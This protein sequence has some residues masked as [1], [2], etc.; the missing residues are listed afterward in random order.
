MGG[1]DDGL[2]AR[3]FAMWVRFAL[4]LLHVLSGGLLG[5]PGGTGGERVIVR[6]CRP[7]EVIDVR[8]AVL[9]PGRP[10]DTAIFAGDDAPTTRHWLATLAGRGVGV[11]TVLDSREPDEADPAVLQL[12]GMAVL[13]EVQG[14]GVGRALLD[15]VWAELAP[16][17]LWCNAREKAIPFYTRCGWVE[18]GD[19]FEIA[20]I[21]PH[22]R[23]RWIGGP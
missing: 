5:E 19:R 8:H 21:G 9:R 2:L 12:R 20:P 18:R 16:G 22:V 14:R 17:P 23:M 15:A 7:D 3:F 1:S 13:D 4:G 11:V 10:R 6:R